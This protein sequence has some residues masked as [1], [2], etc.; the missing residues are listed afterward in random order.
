MTTRRE[1]IAA[2]AAAAEAALAAAAAGTPPAGGTADPGAPAAPATPAVADPAATPASPTADA[3]TPPAPAPTAAPAA[4]APAV[5]DIEQRYNSLQ[6]MFNRQAAENADLKARLDQTLRLA[7]LQRTAAPAAPAAA[8]TPPPSLVSASE[9][10]EFGPDLID[11]AQRAARE[12]YLPLITALQ[13][14]V[15]RLEQTIAQQSQTVQRVEAVA[16]QTA[17]QKFEADLTAAA[18]AAGYDWKA[19]NL[20]PKFLDFLDEED[21]F[22]GEKRLSLFQRAAQQLDAKRVSSFFGAYA[23]GMTAARPLDG[24][25]SPASGT[26]APIVDPR[27][28]VTPGPAA[29]APATTAPANGKIWTQAEVEKVYDDRMKQR[30]TAEQFAVQEAAV[31]KAINEGRVRG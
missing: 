17:E 20:D 4:A 12:Q 14:R 7:E 24:G 22:S 27:S 9:R 8:P 1:R 16:A 31:L 29:P 10:E 5:S 3:G 15:A 13:G 2:E 19:I 11:V 30:I 6:G 28:L 18:A 26:A 25:N 23:K 21:T